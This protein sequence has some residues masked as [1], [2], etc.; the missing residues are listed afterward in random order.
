[1]VV[2]P[3]KSHLVR[4]RF[5]PAIRYLDLFFLS[6][7][8]VLFYPGLGSSEDEVFSTPPPPLPLFGWKDWKVSELE[9]VRIDKCQN[10]KVSELESVKIEKF[11]NQDVSESE[12]IS[13]RMCPFQK[14]SELKSLEIKKSV[15]V[16][17]V[18][19]EKCRDL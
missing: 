3:H 12:F 7:F 2:C 9:S 15:T 16:K 18:R 14:V 17:S 5:F 19:M 11:Q 8:S 13:A 4:N 10:W 6:S 1:M